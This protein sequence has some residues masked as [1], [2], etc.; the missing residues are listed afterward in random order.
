MCGCPVGWEEVRKGC[1]RAG[2]ILVGFWAREIEQNQEA[3]LLGARW[4]S[5]GTDS[6]W[7]A[8]T[9]FWAGQMHQRSAASSRTTAFLSAFLYNE[10][11]V[12][13]S[14]TRRL[15]Q[16]RYN[17]VISSKEPSG[18]AFQGGSFRLETTLNRLMARFFW[19]GIHENVCRWCASCR[20]WQLVNPQ[21]SPKAPLRLLPLMQIPFE[22]IGM[23]LIRPLKQS[24]I[25][26]HFAFILMDYA[27]EKH[28]CKLQL[29]IYWQAITWRRGSLE[30]NAGF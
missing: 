16:W 13:S 21:V 15:D 28:P 4:L 30:K 2:R 7:N 20:E 23:D 8:K 11:P 25:K 24:A 18:N 10:Q 27:T 26:I 3:D 19:P 22:R 29:E 14:D 1:A 5:P 6:G 17:P 12:V 9:G